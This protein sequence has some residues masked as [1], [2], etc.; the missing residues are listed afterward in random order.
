MPGRRLALATNAN[1]TPLTTQALL[2]ARLHSEAHAQD[3]GDILKSTVGIIFMGT[4]FRGTESAALVHI[5]TRVTSLF[6]E[7]DTSLVNQISS[8]SESLKDVLYD[9][10]LLINQSLISLFCFFEQHKT[11]LAKIAR[12]KLFLFPTYRV[13]FFGKEI[14]DANFWLVVC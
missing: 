14:A 11:D 9:F 8:G 7:S 1:T 2:F 5:F 4:P 12:R 3:F 6:V 13:S 10:C